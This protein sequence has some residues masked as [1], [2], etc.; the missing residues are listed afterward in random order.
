MSVCRCRCEKRKERS[1]HDQGGRGGS[2]ATTKRHLAGHVGFAE[3]DM[4]AEREEA[5]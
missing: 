3:R 5:L 2:P 1:G 4:R